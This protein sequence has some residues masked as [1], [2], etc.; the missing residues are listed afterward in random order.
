MNGSGVFASFC[1]V[2]KDSVRISVPNVMLRVPCEKYVRGVPHV[3][4]FP[5]S[6]IVKSGREFLL[7]SGE[8]KVCVN[9]QELGQL[10][11]GAS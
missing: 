1:G 3:K 7:S 2:D 8:C 9:I 6:K 11:K 4:M 10:R 5:E